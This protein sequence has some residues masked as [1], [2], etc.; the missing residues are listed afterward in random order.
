MRLKNSQ[1][2]KFV[3]TTVLIFVFLHY[4]IWRTVSSSK[5]VTKRPSVGATTT[6]I[7]SSPKNHTRKPYL[8]AAVIVVRIY[9]EDKA[10][11][12]RKELHQWIQYMKYAGVEHIYLYDNYKY[13]TETIRGWYERTFHPSFITYINWS[14]Y[15]PFSW[16]TQPGNYLHAI[17]NY[18]NDSKWHLAFDM[19]EYPF[20]VNDID[21]GF[22]TRFINN[23]SK[24]YPYAS[25]FVFKNFLFLG[26][27]TNRT[28]LVERMLRRTRNVSNK[29]VKPLYKPECVQRALMH[30]NEL[31][32]GYQMEVDPTVMRM[33]H[34]WGAR[35][36]HWGDDTPETLRQTI[37]DNS[38]LRLLTK[39]KQWKKKVKKQSSS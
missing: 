16:K 34:Y 39:L 20:A 33:N 23:H 8:V 22:L 15:H 31:K 11:L 1:I 12:T 18:K 7:N 29:L 17:Y 5:S 30:G 19:D 4:E 35:L 36:Q 9:E 37:P 2:I 24:L 14:M 21:R 3:V 10:K 25:E 13:P 38:M 32:C 26:K 28:Y 6:R 27:P